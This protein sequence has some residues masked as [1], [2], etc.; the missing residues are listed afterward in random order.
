MYFSYDALHH[1]PHVELDDDAKAA[2]S[3]QHVNNII[4]YFLWII[5]EV[6]RDKDTN[7]EIK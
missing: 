5:H 7:F 4:G 3:R 2:Y 6:P 1:N